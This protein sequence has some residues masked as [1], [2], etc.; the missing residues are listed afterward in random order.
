MKK[1]WSFNNIFSLFVVFVVSLLISKTILIALFFVFIFEG[2]R[3]AIDLYFSIKKMP[4]FEKWLSFLTDILIVL[5]LTFAVYNLFFSPAELLLVNIFYI[6]PKIP[7]IYSNLF[8]IVIF[9]L[10]LF[11]NWRKVKGRFF[12]GF[13]LVLEIVGA[14]IYLGCRKEKLAR[15][16]LP[17]IYDVSR[18]AGYQGEK[19]EISGVNF[20]PAFKRGRVILGKAGELQILLWSE[21][22]IIGIIPVPAKFGVVDLGVAREDGITSNIIKF[23]IKDPGK[24]KN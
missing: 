4:R 22:K 5:F 17:K 7:M 24:L 3:L 11:F 13:L 2:V 9:L 16:Y 23:E 1:F 20:Y 14:I 8:F 21:N 6:I 15:E 12:F 18:L 19:L 10:F